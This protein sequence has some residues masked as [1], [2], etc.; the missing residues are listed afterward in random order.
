[1]DPTNQLLKVG[2]RA[3]IGVD[4]MI[5]GDGIRRACAA[6]GNVGMRARTLGGMFQDARQLDMGEAQ[7]LDGIKSGF[8]NIIESTAAVFGLAAVDAEVSL[9]VAKQSGEE[10]I[11]VHTAKLEKLTQKTKSMKN[12]YLC[13][14]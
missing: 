13:T 7:V 11:D 12:C 4:G 2:H 6:F 5:I 9:F 8:V 10:L 1:M 3:Q 14:L